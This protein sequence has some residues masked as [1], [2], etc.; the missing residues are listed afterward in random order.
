MQDKEE[1]V[2]IVNEQDEIVRQATK[3]EA[4]AKGLLHRTVI[5]EL[6][7]SKGEWVLVKQAADRQDAG[8]YVSP[9]G[10]HVDGGE[11]E[12]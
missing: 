11:I 5:S 12:E 7:N 10:G 8:Q 1:T 3:I 6:I 2:D 9:M 4:H